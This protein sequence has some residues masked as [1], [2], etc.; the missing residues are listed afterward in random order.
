MG[1]KSIASENEPANRV[2]FLN[3]PELTVVSQSEEH[4]VLDA[5]KPHT[6]KIGDLFYGLP[7]HICPSCAV[8]DSAVTVEK[9]EVTGAWEIISRKRKITI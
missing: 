8:Y 2:Y 9:G 4:A 7:I 1:Y 3:A 6:W 5:G